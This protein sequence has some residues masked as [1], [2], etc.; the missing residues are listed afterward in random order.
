MEEDQSSEGGISRRTFVGGTAAAAGIAGVTEAATAIAQGDPAGAAD[1]AAAEM[2]KVATPYKRPYPRA[3]G[4]SA[5]KT[6]TFEAFLGDPDYLEIWCYTDQLSYFP[7]DT[8]KLHLSTTAKSFSV[9]IARDGFQPAIAHVAESV[10]GKFAP[11]GENFQEKGCNWPVGYEWKLPRDM[12]SGFYLVTLRAENEAGDVREYDHGFF[13]RRSQRSTKA[14]ILLVAA[15]STRHAYNDWGGYSHYVNADPS[16]ETH[17]ARLTNHFRPFA[18]GQLWMPVNAPRKPHE[19]DLPPGGIPRYPCIEF[20]LSMGYSRWYCNAGWA[21]YERPF[22]IWAEK[23]GYEIDFATQEDLHYDEELLTGYKCV[24][25]VGHDEYWSWEM[26]DAIERFVSDGGNMA[27]FA[28]NMAWQIRLENEGTV[29]VCYKDKAHFQDP[30]VGSPQMNRLTSIWS[31]PL[32]GRPGETTFG[33]SADYGIYA[34]VGINVPRGTG[35][36]TVYQPDHWAFAGTDMYYGDVLGAE[37]KI[38][39]YEVDGL[40]YTFEDGAPVVTDSYRGP[41]PTQ[42]LAMGL[43][44]NAEVDH[45]HR[46]SEF[47]YG[48]ASA[49]MG[50]FRRLAQSGQS[51][52]M[53]ALA[54]TGGDPAKMAAVLKFTPQDAVGGARGNGMMVHFAMGE[55]EVFHA[56]SCEWVAGLQGT[57]FATE[58]VTRNVLNRFTGRS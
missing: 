49:A 7:G 39:G 19:F 6:N 27:R 42:I 31:D 50:L 44:S 38:F 53:A 15:T 14:D 12:Q 24:V 35:G 43:A 18:R 4:F 1:E 47:Y 29:Q 8:V 34:G 3:Q 17:Q 40:E 54:A 51:I 20:A 46:G 25:S 5:L 23:N 56:G 30:V 13:V 55:G 36:F 26:R 37:A 52:D 22:V 9:T 28:G 10:P 45:G 11:L 2:A 16:P 57:D 41:K 21:T 58:Q 32:V 48:D 33:L